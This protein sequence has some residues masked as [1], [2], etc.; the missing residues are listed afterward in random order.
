MRRWL[1]ILMMLAVP[2]QMAWAAATPYCVHESAASVHFGHHEY[3]QETSDSSAPDD[4]TGLAAPVHNDCG[5][6]HLAH[7]G[8]IGH[9]DTQFPMIRMVVQDR[10]ERPYSSYIPLGP[11]RPQR[12]IAPSAAR[13]GNGALLLNSS[14]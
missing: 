4:G 10:L 6:C 9:T 14:A 3:C 2:F 8:W 7:A 12:R 11:E 5:S 13:S 1:I